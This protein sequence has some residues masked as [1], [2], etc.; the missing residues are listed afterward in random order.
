MSCVILCC[1]FAPAQAQKYRITTGENE[2]MSSVDEIRLLVEMGWATTLTLSIVLQCREE[3][4]QDVLNRGEPSIEMARNLD[5]LSVSYR[6]A[7]RIV[8]ANALKQSIGDLNSPH[9]A[10]DSS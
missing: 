4:I 1:E 5:A 9:L 6:T 10:R 8:N 7:I 3:A 2:L